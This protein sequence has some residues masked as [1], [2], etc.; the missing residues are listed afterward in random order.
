M[1]VLVIWNR[2]PL[3]RTS[4]RRRLFPEEAVDWDNE[5]VQIRG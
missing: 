4:S 1:Q 2:V 3:L 5:A